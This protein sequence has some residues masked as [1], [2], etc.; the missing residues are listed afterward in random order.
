MTGSGVAPQ[1]LVVLD[2]ERCIGSGMCVAYA[3]G[4]FTH[5]EQAKAMV[6][7]PPGDPIDVISTAVEAC[8]TGALRLVT[9][10]TGA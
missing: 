8:P 6:I 3:P 9:D 4:A 2:R 1:P 7:D 10:E 5:D